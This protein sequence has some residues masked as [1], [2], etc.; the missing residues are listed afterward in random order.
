LGLM[1][2]Q[3]GTN[4]NK[5]LNSCADT[6][7]TK[8][9]EEALTFYHKFSTLPN[10]TWDNS[11]DNSILAFAGGKVAMIFAP[12]W[13]A[14][15]INEINPNLK[16]KTAKVPQLPCN[17]NPCPEINW[18]S[19]W[20]EGVSVKSKNQSQAWL[21]LKYL[22]S[23]SV[24]EK[25]YAE[26]TKIRKLFGEPFSR[27]DLGA[28]LKDNPY[29]APLISMAPNMKSF[30]LSGRTNDGKTGLNTSLIGYLKDAVNSINDKGVS[31]ETALKTADSGFAEVFKRF[32]IAPAQ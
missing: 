25:L 11:L 22:T 26:Q 20:V 1:M 29:L 7:S 4:L 3:N 30:Y 23:K 18:A 10:N 8:C 17:Q 14:H 2:L 28:S 5:S 24:E 12:S 13:Q 31:E 16:F 6:S 15:I 27:V 32:N 21:F 19:Y 9:T